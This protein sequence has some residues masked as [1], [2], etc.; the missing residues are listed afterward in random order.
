MSSVDIPLGD[1]EADETLYESYNA[2]DE[3]ERRFD[4]IITALE[5]AV[6]APSFRD[7]IVAFC[8]DNCRAFIPGV[9]ENTMEQHALFA[10]YEKLTE[11]RVEREVAARV[12]G[13]DMAAFEEMLAQPGRAEALSGD[14]MDLLMAFGDYDEF[15]S[16][17]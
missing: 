7:P 1:G 9:E 14:V 13:F 17:A 10:Q 2:G 5:D 11:A 16:S 4:E 15:K 3:A 6:M 12:P 8:R